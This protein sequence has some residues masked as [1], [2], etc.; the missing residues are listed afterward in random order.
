MTSKA[1]WFRAAAATIL[2]MS[3]VAI[4]GAGQA[5]KIDV[6]GA[7][8]FTVTSELG[9]TNP[10]V[11]LKQDGEKIT[12]RYSS[13]LFGDADLAGTVKG[14]TIA[15]TVSASIEGMKIELRYNGT[16]E[17]N[18]AIKGEMSAGDLGGGTFTAARK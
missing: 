12:G 9:T 16:V 18:T 11:T 8:V 15:F 7:W 17:S 2:T 3:S 4:A 13:Q 5:A 1:R 10:A 14:Q 6:T